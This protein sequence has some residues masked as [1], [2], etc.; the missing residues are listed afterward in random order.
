MAP[1]AAS[2]SVT[3]PIPWRRALRWT[4][5]AMLAAGISGFVV[6]GVLGRGAMRILAL[7]SPSIAQGRLTDDAARVGQFTLS[8]SLGLAIAIGFGSALIVGPAYL[9]ARRILPGSRW[10]RVGGMALATGA[11]GGA[12]LV[13]DHPSFD[14][15]ILQPTWLAVALFLAIPAGVGALSAYLTERLAPS[16]GPPLRGRLAGVW[17]GGTVTAV[18]TG[19]YWFV[20]SWG[21]YNIGADVMSL[22]LGRASSVPFT[23]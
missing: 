6:G 14:Y 20:V 17:R 19:G 12:V 21:L 5:T 2:P 11:V 9:L 23:V 10:G 13:H 3:S 8:G 16:A 15:T 1:I 22:A 7:T 4:L 18:L